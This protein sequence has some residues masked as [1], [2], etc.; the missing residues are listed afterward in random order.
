M[1]SDPADQDSPSRPKQ[2]VHATARDLE[3]IRKIIRPLLGNPGWDAGIGYGSFLTI[4]FG[5]ARDIGRRRDGTPLTGGE[6]HLWIYCS[7]WRVETPTA[8]LGASE[9]PRD[10]M[11]AAAASLNGRP[12]VAVELSLPSLETTF[13]FEGGHQLRVF[14][15]Y[16]SPGES[17]PEHWMLYTP[18]YMVLNVGPASSWSYHRSDLPDRPSGG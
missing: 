8:V 13:R 12:L 10:R 5:A 6:W 7:A 3:E 17:D 9:D 16:T 4:E 11:S 14:P 18:D 15:I 2:G 1:S